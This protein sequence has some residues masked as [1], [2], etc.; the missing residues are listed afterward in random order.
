MAHYNAP[1]FYIELERRTVKRFRRVISYSFGSSVGLYIVM[2]SFGFLTFGVNCDGYVLNN[3][4]DYDN[5]ANMCRCAIAFAIVFTY[6]IVFMGFRDGVFDLLPI[7]TAQ[8]TAHL[9]NLMTVVLLVLVTVLAALFDNLG[10]LNAIGG[11]T[12]ATAVVFI[13]PTMMYRGALLHNNLSLDG[14]KPDELREVRLVTILMMF[15][16]VMG[17]VGVWM[18]IADLQR[19]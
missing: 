10:M 7:S 14:A 1:R 11:G 4:S 18:G 8:E 16:I 5:L 9:S 12:I 2:A 13:F 15:G 3:Y 6:P 19:K 17:L